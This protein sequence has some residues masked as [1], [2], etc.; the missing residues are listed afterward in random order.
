MKLTIT[1]LSGLLMSVPALASNVICSKSGSAHSTLKAIAWNTESRI[2]TLKT[3]TGDELK[4][5]VTAV[6]DHS[7]GKKV[8]M[9]FEHNPP[10]YGADKTEFVV[11]P[12]SRS[13]RAIGVTYAEVEGSTLLD[14]SQ[15]NTEVSCMEL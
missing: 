10:Y 9:L 4:G 2:A 5:M 1:L 14:T 7:N 11:F 3:T 15:G 6:R 12:V 13:H 8:N